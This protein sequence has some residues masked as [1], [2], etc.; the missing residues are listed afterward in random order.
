[1]DYLEKARRVISLEIEEL[2]QLLESVGDGFIAAVDTLKASVDSGAKVIIVG[3][4]KSGN[5]GSKLAATFNSTGAPS[6]V[7][8]CQ[9]ALHGDLGIVNDGDTIL[10][11][12]YSG[13]TAELLG[14]LPHLKRKRV[15]IVAITGK[16]ESTLAK[17]SDAVVNVMVSREACP[18]N[19]A[20]TSSTT[21]TLVVGDALAMVLLEARGFTKERFAELHP[22]GSLGRALLMRAADIM[23]SGD[24]FVTVSPD[25]PILDVISKMT[26]ARAGAVVV[27]DDSGKLAGVFTQGD[28]ARSFQEDSS[29]IAAVPVGEIM[30]KNPK[31]VVV[32]Q[33]VG[34]VLRFLEEY[35]IDDLVVVDAE[36]SAVG[37]IDTQDL[38]RLQ[39]V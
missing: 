30:T 29:N 26:K 27:V 39:I 4:G 37:M 19:L 38:T 22:G 6:I 17:A 35:R 3:V 11:L 34:E 24:D 16:P 20:P 2:Q 8:N 28:F 33:L 18:L 7:L 32:D 1:M 13:E 15:S 5:I 14:L 25:T 9:D 23:R 10:A 12:S 21:N 36:G 31:F